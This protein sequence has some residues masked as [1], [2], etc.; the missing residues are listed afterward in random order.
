M[1]F[2]GEIREKNT[3]NSPYFKEIYQLVGLLPVVILTK[4]QKEL[5][6]REFLTAGNSLESGKRMRVIANTSPTSPQIRRPAKAFKSS[7]ASAV[8]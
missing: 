5:E 1:K 3:Y 8:G 6:Q 4:N 2:Q 7:E